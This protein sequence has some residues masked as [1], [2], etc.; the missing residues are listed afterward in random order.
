MSNATPKPMYSN[1][2]K[3]ERAAEL[4][5][6]LI[7]L[8]RRVRYDG[9]CWVWCGATKTNG[10][11]VITADKATMYAHRLAYWV[12]KGPIPTGLVVDHLC[13]NRSCINPM[14]LEAVSSLENTHRGHGNAVRTACPQGHAYDAGNTR[15]WTDGNGYTRRYCIACTNARNAR[16]YT[17]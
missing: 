6:A 11:G 4:P 9:Q 10:Y 3:Y 5:D 7:R 8:I 12:A 14:H 2:G 13:R 15:T 16:R 1:S 17:D